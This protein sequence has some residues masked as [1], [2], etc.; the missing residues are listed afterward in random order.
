[1]KI[2]GIKISIIGAGF[3]GSTTAFSIMS[4]GLAS[5]IVIV[6]VNKD[7]AEGEAM[8]LAH[9]VSFVKPV[10]IKSGDYKDTE[11]SNIVIITAGSG[12]KPGESRLDLINRNY[13]IFKS[14]VPEVVKY[15]PKSILLVVSN[16]VDILT[17]ITY[18]LSGFPPERIIGSGTVLD[19]SRLRYM[20]SE[21][22]NIDARNIH[23]YIIGEHGDSEIATWSST[24]IAGIPL[25]QYC[26]LMDTSCDSDYQDRIINNVRNAA[27]EVIERKGSTYFAV[28]LAVRRIVEALSRDEN[29]IMTVSALFSG[30]YD[31][32]N[33]YMGLPA[34]IGSEGIQ[35]TLRVPLNSAEKTALQTSADTLK[36]I[37]EKLNI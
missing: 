21:N 3:V 10:D 6:D 17:Y 19:T 13:S 25:E 9:G 36:D 8:D 1:M 7:K 5:E 20:I 12:Q 26:N 27:Y 37:I 23:S 15:S 4:S 11:E 35:K 16:P 34:V 31:I 24:S 22:F 2:R 14:I 32:D 29:S 33:V 30:E 18:K 28:A